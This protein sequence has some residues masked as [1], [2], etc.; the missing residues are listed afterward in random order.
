M[1][2]NSRLVQI[3]FDVLRGVVLGIMICYGIL[4]ATQFGA[5]DIVFRYAGY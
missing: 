2:T 5:T 4:A 1:T 3:T